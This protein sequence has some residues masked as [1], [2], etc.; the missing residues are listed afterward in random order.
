VLSGWEASP[1]PNPIKVVTSRGT[2]AEPVPPAPRQD[3]GA[4][5][6]RGTRR[7]G[8]IVTILA[9]AGAALAK[10]KVLLLGLFKLKGLLVVAKTGGSMLLMVGAYALLWPWQ[11]ALGATLLLLVH[12]LGHALVLRYLGVPFSAPIFIPFVGALIG[13]KELPP[14]A[15]K[16]ALMAYGGPFLGTVGAQTCFYLYYQTGHTLFL[17]LAQFGFLINLF[18]LA[19]FSPLDG[20]RIVGAISPRIWLFALPAMLAAGIYLRSIILLLVTALGVPRA[21]KVWRSDPATQ[22]YFD[23]PASTRLTAALGYLVL[24]GFLAGMMHEAGQVYSAVTRG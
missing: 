11:F 7:R 12:E 9:M 2:L 18:N 20:G 4:G 13:I 14:D 15:G 8:V 5:Q 16:E 10:G 19:P 23:L 22:A 6:K 3:A 21:I 24:A 17:G 1:A